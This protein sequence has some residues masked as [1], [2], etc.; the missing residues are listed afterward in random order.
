MEIINFE[1]EEYYKLDMLD[2]Y[3]SKSGSIVSHKKNKFKKLKL[4]V[5][6]RG[7]IVV[8][9]FYNGARFQ[10]LL[11]RLIAEY[12]IPNPDNL[13]EVNHINGNKLDNSV[14]NLE[15]CCKKYNVYHYH[16]FIKNK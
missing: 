14:D 7:Y 6:S 10:E 16:N 9:L 3:L 11:H 5:G 15:W 8:T 2:Y 13:L 1:N 12:F 4:S